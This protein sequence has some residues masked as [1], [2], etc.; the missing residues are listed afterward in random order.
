M[1]DGDHF[2]LKVAAQQAHKN[3]IPLKSLPGNSLIFIKL[4][5][6]SVIS[7]TE[8]LNTYEK[9]KNIKIQLK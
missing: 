5:G 1:S 7:Q 9:I 6:S 8:M 3:G 4:L 2:S